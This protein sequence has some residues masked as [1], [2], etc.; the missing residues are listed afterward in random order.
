MDGRDGAGDTKRFQESADRII[1]FMGVSLDRKAGS[2][3]SQD[4]EREFHKELK[5]LRI[6]DYVYFKFV[7]PFKVMLNT[8]KDKDAKRYIK[9]LMKI[10]EKMF[11]NG[12]IYR[13]LDGKWRYWIDDR[14]A[15]LKENICNTIRR[16]WSIVLRWSAKS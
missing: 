6:P 11:E 9:A 13:G 7:Y 10:N 1:R 8:K 14:N 5:R 15:S 12:N 2:V 16:K 3:S 4:M